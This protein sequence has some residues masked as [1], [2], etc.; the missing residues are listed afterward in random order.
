MRY[1]TFSLCKLDETYACYRKTT[2]IWAKK[3]TEDFLV[4]TLEG[5]MEGHAGDYLAVGKLGERYPIR[6][7]IF[8]KTYELTEPDAPV[9]E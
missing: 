5:L 2:K 9:A 1:G 6:A 8:E 3:M 7:D 4:D